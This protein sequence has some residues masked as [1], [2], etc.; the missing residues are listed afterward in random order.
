MHHAP[1]IVFDRVNLDFDGKPLFQ[2]LSLTLNGGQTTC[3]LGPSGCGKSTLLK[4]IAGVSPLPYT[5]TIHLSSTTR[6]TSYNVCY[7]KLLRSRSF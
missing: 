6:I 5:G 2:D 4:L 7:T 3:I 1:Q